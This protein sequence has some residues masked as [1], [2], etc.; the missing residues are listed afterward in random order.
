[1]FNYYKE[2]GEI[3][4]NAN[5]DDIVNEMKPWYDNYR[6]LDNIIGKYSYSRIK[7]TEKCIIDL[8]LRVG[9]ITG[10]EIGKMTIHN[11]VLS[12]EI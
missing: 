12:T 8:F 4:A 6:M 5:I 9:H 1:M 10:F 3:A 11:R 7:F 2:K